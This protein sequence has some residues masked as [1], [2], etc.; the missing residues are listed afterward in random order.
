MEIQE[1]LNNA[2]N[3][4]IELKLINE[5]EEDVKAFLANVIGLSEKEIQNYF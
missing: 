1:Q 4:I 5:P 2:I 3:Y